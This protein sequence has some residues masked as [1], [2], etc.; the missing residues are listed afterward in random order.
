MKAGRFRSPIV[1]CNTNKDVFRAL[2][3]ILE[4]LL[5]IL[6]KNIEIPIV[7]EY[8]CIEQ[9]ILEFLPRALPVRFDKVTV[10]IRSLRILVEVFHIRVGGCAVDVEVVLLDVLTVVPLAVG[11]PKQSLFENRV[12]LVPQCQG[13]TKSLLVIADAAEPIFTP[14]V[15]PRARLIMGEIVPRIAVL[16]IVFAD[17]APLPL[18]EVWA[19]FLPRDLRLARFVQAFLLS[20]IDNRG[21]HHLPL[22]I[23]CLPGCIRG[24]KRF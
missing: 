6:D 2:L 9:L 13:K 24:T 15:S 14:A 17:R 22:S 4:A 21:V 19:P 5:R 10:G 7:I 8:A 1:H 18:A 16:A 11:E 12:P 20:N 23:L 3:R